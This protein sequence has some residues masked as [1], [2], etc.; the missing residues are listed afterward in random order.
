MNDLI[1]NDFAPKKVGVTEVTVS[2]CQDGDSNSG[3]FQLLEVKTEDAGGGSFFVIKTERWAFDKIDD[4]INI[5][6]DFKKR[7]NIEEDK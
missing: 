5:L 3:A 1:P 4:L 6:N 7:I 2:Y